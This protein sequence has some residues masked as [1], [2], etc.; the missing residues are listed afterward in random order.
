MEGFITRKGLSSSVGAD[1]FS[2]PSQSVIE[3]VGLGFPHRVGR[4]GPRGTVFSSPGCW[5]RKYLERFLIR[6]WGFIVAR[7]LLRYFRAL[8]YHR[9]AGGNEFPHRAGWCPTGR[10][11]ANQWWSQ[12]GWGFHHRVERYRVRGTRFSAPCCWSCG[13]MDRFRTPG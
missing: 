5:I 2:S 6:G 13:C 8:P 3:L 7:P 10:I 12:W 11:A 1:L 9:S 4:K